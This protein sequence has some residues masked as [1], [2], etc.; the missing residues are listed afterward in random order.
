VG[1]KNCIKKIMSEVKIDAVNIQYLPALISCYLI[2]LKKINYLFHGPWSLEYIS[3]LKGRS[4]RKN[5]LINIFLDYLILPVLRR[6]EE[7]FLHKCC[8]K[9][10]VLSQFM[11][12]SLEDNFMV[13]INMITIC[14]G[15]INLNDFYPE[16]SDPF[17]LKISKKKYIFL[18]VR[19]LERRMGLE[20]LIMA[21]AQLKKRNID[22]DLLIGGQGPMRERLNSLVYQLGVG[23][24]VRFLGYIPEEEL[25]RYLSISDLFLLL[26]AEL[27]GFGLVML[28][29]MACGTPALVSLYSGSSEVIMK[30]DKRF[31]C[32]KLEPNLIA[33]QIED[34]INKELLGSNTSKASV[35]FV[36]NNYSWERFGKKFSEWIVN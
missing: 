2:S 34:L 23:E 22:F 7:F 16:Y 12:S 1:F 5:S 31:I 21:A 25:R 29:S 32:E 28:E 11:R 9:Y 15:G 8:A 18:T 10:L 4:K 26:S 30:F 14:P 13:D 36:Q 19:R 20:N 35:D 3:S 27:E 33:N 17:R 6:L 24:C